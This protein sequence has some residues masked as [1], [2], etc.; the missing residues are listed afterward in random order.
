[1][2]YIILMVASLKVGAQQNL[3]G[4]WRLNDMKTLTGQDYA[5]AVPNLIKVQQTVGTITIELTSTL[6]DRDTIITEHL[7]IGADQINES[8]TSTGKQKRTTLSWNESRKA[9]IKQSVIFA[10]DNPT[11]PER[12]TEEE[13]VLTDGTVVLSK[14]SETIDKTKKEG[15]FTA[16]GFYVKTSA[17][18]TERGKGI[19]FTEGLSWEQIKAKAKKEN[20]F[21]FVDCYATWCGPCKVMDKDVYPL[22]MVGDAMNRRFISVKVQMDSTKSDPAHI[23]LMYPTAR[24]L[25]KAYEVSALPTYLFFSPEGIAVHKAIGQQSGSGFVKLVSKAINPNEQF[26]TLINNARQGKL[27]YSEF[28]ALALKLKNEF[29]ENDLADEIAKTYKEKYLDKLSEKE[30]LKKEHLDFI[31]ENFKLINTKD[32]FF[33]LCYEQPAL[34]DKI[35]EYTKGGWADFQVNQ[36]IMRE[37]II[38]FVSLAEQQKKEPQ[39][40]LLEQEL[41][42]EFNK[43]LAITYVLDARV[44]WYKKKKQWD[45]YFNYLPKQIDR[46]GLNKFPPAQLNS[47]AWAVFKHCDDKAL[48]KKALEWIDVSIDK[49]PQELRWMT[50][51]TKACLL[52]KI[53]M[54]KDAILLEEKIIEM[55]PEFINSFLPTVEKMKR[56][57][58][59]WLTLR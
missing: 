53:G 16:Q 9:W 1:M 40:S 42:K 7:K 51:D 54:K 17:Y 57:E 23:K 10:K 4:W 12:I 2:L 45:V 31:G 26:Y 5:N 55:F 58:A 37:Y 52:Y 3:S 59:F 36:T 20:K 18:E 38:P 43:E 22:N 15:N 14:K 30:L 32:K 48:M 11:Q 46:H 56:D 13:Y 39:W 6:G 24:L 28:P 35:K 19:Q 49:T 44:G 34:V 29:K 8:Q 41:S 27:A 47:A 50:M 33:K 25:E 21:I